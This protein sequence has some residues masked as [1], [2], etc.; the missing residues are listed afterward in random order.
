VALQH[1]LARQWLKRS[2]DDPGALERGNLRRIAPVV[3]GE[4]PVP[5]LQGIAYACSLVDL[6]VREHA[7]SI[8]VDASPDVGTACRAL[9]PGRHRVL[10]DQHGGR[11]V[12]QVLCVL[13]L[14]VVECVI[15][16]AIDAGADRGATVHAVR[17]PVARDRCA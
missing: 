3:G 16:I 1:D 2:D 11:H 15:A 9:E 14:G 6:G 12:A 13:D 8:I 5:Q 17:T 4:V 10:A 7:I